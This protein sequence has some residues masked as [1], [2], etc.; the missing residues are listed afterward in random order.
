MEKNDYLIAAYSKWV[1]TI[2]PNDYSI[3]TKNGHINAQQILSEMENE[4]LFGI[5]FKTSIEKVHK[6]IAIDPL[7]NAKTDDL[8]ILVGYYT[9]DAKQIIEQITTQETEF[10]KNFSDS[11]L[12]FTIS[13]I[14]ES[15]KN[16]KGKV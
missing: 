5:N 8:K 13:V 16:K 7:Q 4:T 9:F 15:I 2:N 3:K 6:Q 10:G 12:S 14:M 1:S 11:M